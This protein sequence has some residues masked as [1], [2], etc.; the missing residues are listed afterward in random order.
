MASIV[1]IRKA[2]LE[3]L[4]PPERLPLSDWIERH[5]VLPE[6]TS[7]MP[8]R[9]RLWPYQKGIADAIGDASVERV[10]LVKGVRVGF[11]TLLT[12][13]IGSYVVNEPAPL[14]V[15]LPTE[16][17]ARDYVVSD[18]EPIFAATPA[19]RGAL[20]DD[21][22]E[23]ERNT[24]LHRRFAG[25]SLKCVA[26]KAPRNLR[27]HSARVL[28]VDEA[29]GMEVGAE[30]APIRL[31][32]RRTLSFPN[33]KIIIGSTPLFE[34]TSAVLRAYA[35]SDQRIFECPCPSCGEFHEI[36][37][38]DIVWEP[39]NAALAAYKCPA[40]GDLIPEAAKPGM[41]EK[42]RW[43]ATRPEIEG[44]A[45]FRLSALVS[46]HS[47]AAWSKLAAEFLQA[48]DDPAQLQVFTNTI[49]AQGWK[50]EGEEV[51]EGAL[52]SRGEN[53][54]LDR[55]PA[56]V[57][58]VTC[59]CDVQDDRVEA[60]VTGWNHEGGCLVLAHETI[61]GQYDSDETWQALDELLKSR[62]KHPA[63]GRLKV[64]ASCIDAGDGQ[65]YPK[66]LAFCGPR[67]ARRVMAS[68]GASGWQRPPIVAS[69]GKVQ[70]GARLWICGIDPLKATI[71]SRLQRGSAIRFSADVEGV[72][73]EQL[74]SE[75]MVVRYKRG[76]PTR[77][78]VRVPGRRAE[79]LDALVYAHAAFA[80]LG[81]VNFDARLAE[82]SQ[83]TPPAKPPSVFPSAW[84]SR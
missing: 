71:F 27:R 7:A 23:G 69:T 17:D 79:A 84:M 56:E 10:T 82:L 43:R 73:F 51:D 49:L 59:G 45:G 16:A 81:R 29:D 76:Q 2:A 74:S 34:D 30:G 21:V 14:L 46:L 9:V 58:V 32:E 44:H 66:V 33:R 61:W 1:E 31:A 19:L 4:R 39:D 47:N 12:G 77:Q 48:K 24:L 62:W 67:A 28:L 35:E 36:G 78:F 42:G 3:A 63:G 50:G 25:G 40:C 41:V 68:K 13:C 80:A 11:T 57:L 6:G 53:F 37:W 54:G 70:R 5:L 22:E 15:L 20:S 8:G 75:R 38:A 52:A 64:D 55:I 72:F 83:P 65:H 26:A 60:V 18:I